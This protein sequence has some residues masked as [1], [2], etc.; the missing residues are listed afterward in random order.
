MSDSKN[1]TSDSKSDTSTGKV[2]A[3]DG[4]AD[5]RDGKK[6]SR[7]RLALRIVVSVVLCVAVLAGATGAVLMIYQTEPTAQQGGATRKS[8]ALVETVKAERG[9]YRPEIVVL[10]VVEPARD[11]VLSP[12]VSGQIVE[13]DPAFLPGGIVQKDEP[14]AK[15]DPADFENMIAMRRSALQ[16]A[17][18]SLEI[19][20]GRQDV[21]RQEFALLDEQIDPDNRA[22]VLREPQIESS[23]AQVK[24]AEAALEQAKLDLKRTQVIAPFDAQILTR[25]VNVGSQVTPSDTLGRLVGIDEYWVMATVP[26]R[27]LRWVNFPKRDGEGSLVRVQNADTWGKGVSRRGQVK[28]MIG[29]VDEQTRLAKVLI[30]IP[31][32][33]AQETDA[34]PLILGTLVEA[35][36]EGQPIEDVLRLDRNYVRENDTV[37]VMENGALSIRAVTVVFR[38]ATHAYISEGL[39]DGDE[40]VTTTLATVAEG[41]LLRRVDKTK[42]DDTADKPDADT[43]DK[44]DGDTSDK[45]D[46]EAGD[47][48]DKTDADTEEDAG[49]ND[50]TTEGGSP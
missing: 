11:I 40:V 2:D 27:S 9:S 49:R 18:A 32:P 22:L 33:L 26:L 23:E 7:W 3:S 30:A 44:A 6:E 1:D 25:N 15:I 50:K 36:I 35:R 38:D 13:L 41:V 28:R 8:A 37:W 4:K 47:T 39:E 34:P 21:A 10:G 12:R 45:T 31:D 24:S 20:K 14:L 29:M 19:E 46:A 17:R 48:S 16:Q 42:D 43:S 5:T